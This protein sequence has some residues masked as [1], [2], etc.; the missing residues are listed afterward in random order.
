[1]IDMTELSEIEKAIQENKAKLQV[2]LQEKPSKPE[3]PS[4]EA[5]RLKVLAELKVKEEK[6]ALE[7]S[8]KELQ[9]KVKMIEKNQAEQKEQFESELKKFS[10]N[11]NTGSSYQGSQDNLNNKQK[12]QAMSPEG[13]REFE[14]A[15]RDATFDYFKSRADKR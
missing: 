7:K 12:I 9:E 2:D 8:N 14:E 15:Q 4:E 1:M 3:A 6:E 10:G 11:A 5:I 13:M